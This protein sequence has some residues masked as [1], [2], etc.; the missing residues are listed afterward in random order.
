MSKPLIS[1]LF[2][3]LCFCAS[4]I[5]ANAGVSTANRQEQA[6]AFAALD[7]RARETLQSGHLPRWS[8]PE[9]APLLARLLNQ[10]KTLGTGP[11]TAAD[12]PLLLEISDTNVLAFKSYLMFTPKPG[13]V[14]DTAANTA[15]YQDEVSRLAA[16]QI[17]ATGALAEA[18]DDFVAKLPKAEMSQVRLDGLR[19]M[20]LGLLQQ[21]NGVTLMVRSPGLKPENRGLL[22]NALAENAARIASAATPADR[23]SMVALTDTLLPDLSG[24]DKSKA[25]AVKQAFA[26]TTCEGLCKIDSK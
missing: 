19:Q 26:Q 4:A 5:P 2:L 12:V 11:Y 23:T 18:I 21:V 17:A 3:S 25:L 7:A 1:A 24:D 8:D 16:Y 22:L 14:P 10:E 9:D 6:S 13:T 15:L 20:R